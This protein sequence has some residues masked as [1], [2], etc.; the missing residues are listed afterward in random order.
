MKTQVA[1]IGGGPAGSTAAMFL[2]QRGISSVIIEKAR[3]P[4][5]HVGESMTGEAG[6]A[7]RSLGLQRKMEE[8]GFPQKWGGRV[9]GPNGKNDFFVPLMGRKPDGSLV[10]NYSW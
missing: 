2:R 4:R 10:E 8:G 9:M 7:L 6:N 1:I 5:Y 3:F